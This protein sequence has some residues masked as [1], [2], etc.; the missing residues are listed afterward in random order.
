MLLLKIA[1]WNIN[2]I[3][4]HINDFME[5][6]ETNHPDI[7]CLQEIKTLEESFPVD[8]IE[9]LGYHIETYGQKAFN[10]VAIIS[11]FMPEEVLKGLPGDPQD[12]QARFIEAVFSI[13]SQILRIGNL[14][15]P[16]GN[17][18]LSPKYNYKLAWIER[19]LSFAEERLSLEEPFILAGDYNIIPEP[20]DCYDP[21]AWENDA[22]FVLPI[23]QS[24]KKLKN[25]GFIDAIRAT[26]DS[27]LEYSFWD[28]KNNSWN[29]NKGIRIDHLMLSPEAASYLHSAW[30]DKELR[31]SEKPSDH[32]PV[33]I[34]LTIPS[35]K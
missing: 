24:F 13:N 16:N 3:R 18:F 34:Q 4:A 14:Y 22:L 26:T 31:N 1:T 29:K 6:L 27:V 33:N 28:Y 10:G 12:T 25:L 32:V 21:E 8:R 7:V 30:I 9:S 19:L 5:W 35:P 23:R 15:L 2:S 11:K 17:P 20:H